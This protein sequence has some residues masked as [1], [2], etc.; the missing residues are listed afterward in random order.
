MKSALIKC[1]MKRSCARQRQRMSGNT[2]IEC[3]QC[4]DTGSL[5]QYPT[6]GRWT[7]GTFRHPRSMFSTTQRS[8]DSILYSAILDFEAIQSYGVGSR[9]RYAEPA[10]FWVEPGGWL[11]SKIVIGGVGAEFGCA[12]GNIEFWKSSS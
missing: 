12:L 3:E 4:D 10:S 2:S 5:S 9:D 6:R 8:S 11:I 7:A 1:E